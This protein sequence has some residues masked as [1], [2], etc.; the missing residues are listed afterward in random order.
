MQRLVSF[1]EWLETRDPEL[2]VEVFDK[3]KRRVLGGLGL[4]GAGLA[5]LWG[6]SGSGGDNMPP[7][8][9]PVPHVRPAADKMPA[10][11]PSITASADP[12]GGDF[13]PAEPPAIPSSY[14]NKATKRAWDAREQIKL[15]HALQDAGITVRGGLNTS[16]VPHGTSIDMDGDGRPDNPQ[17]NYFNTSDRTYYG[18]GGKAVWTWDGENLHQVK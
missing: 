18:K 17:E 11:P 7:P 15:L 9:E 2:Y 14:K 3:T 1:E 5:G 6:L 12:R 8:R 13:G 16:G 10:P 4:A